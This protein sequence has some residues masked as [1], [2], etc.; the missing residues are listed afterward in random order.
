VLSTTGY[1]AEEIAALNAE[2]A[3]AGAAAGVQ[4]TF[5]S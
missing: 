5:L 2:G 4:G 3:V 1:S